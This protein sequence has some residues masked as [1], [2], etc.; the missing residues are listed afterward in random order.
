VVSWSVLLPNFI[1]VLISCVDATV[2]ATVHIVHRVSKNVSP[3]ACYN[4]DT[5]E[6]I[7]IFLAEMLPIK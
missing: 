1:P 2:Y 4:F 7:L 6:W 5:R 3:L